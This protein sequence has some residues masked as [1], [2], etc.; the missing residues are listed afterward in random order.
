MW[1]LIKATSEL[2]QQARRL[3]SLSL[4]SAQS[5]ERSEERGKFSREATQQLCDVARFKSLLL[6]LPCLSVCLSCLSS[7]AER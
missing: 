3:P 1:N 7:L 5:S 4:S 6:L 2:Q